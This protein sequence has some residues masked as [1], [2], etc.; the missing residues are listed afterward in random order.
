MLLHP[1]LGIQG[2]LGLLS[3]HPIIPLQGGGGLHKVAKDAKNAIFTEIAENCKANQH[4]SQGPPHQ[5]PQSWDP[6]KFF[7]SRRRIC[8][9]LST[10]THMALNLRIFVL[11]IPLSVSR[12]GVNIWCQHL[13][14]TFGV[15]IWCQ[16]LVSIF[17]VNI[18]CQH[19]VSIFGVHIGCQH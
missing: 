5:A 4:S 18:G 7:P 1:A 13:V 2:L 16:H 10:S 12:F 3:Q 8:E 6:K 15:N 17:G 14:S 19:W 11:Y 9:S